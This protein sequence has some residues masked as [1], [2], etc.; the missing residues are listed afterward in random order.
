[1]LRKLL[2]AE[3]KSRNG[4]PEEE[5]A[6]EGLLHRGLIVLFA[7]T[8]AKAYISKRWRKP[9]NISLQ[10]QRSTLGF[11]WGRSEPEGGVNMGISIL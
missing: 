7:A 8:H 4:G 10:V 5:A 3:H 11:L 2:L 6:D 1:M 9:Q